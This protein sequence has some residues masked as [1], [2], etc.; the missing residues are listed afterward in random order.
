VTSEKWAVRPAGGT[1]A[2][3]RR[4]ATRMSRMPLRGLGWLGDGRDVY[5]ENQENRFAD[6][7]AWRAD[8]LRQLGHPGTTF[9][10]C[11]TQPS[12]GGEN[13]WESGGGPWGA[14]YPHF[15]GWGAGGKRQER[16]SQQIGQKEATT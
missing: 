1:S 7:N 6:R 10:R 12:G 4:G 15:K 3:G 11:A 13:G 14:S 9:S 5:I 16:F 8:G 2:G